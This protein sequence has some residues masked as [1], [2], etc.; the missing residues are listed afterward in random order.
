VRRPADSAP[1]WQCP[2]CG[3]AIEKFLASQRPAPAAAAV[4][5]APASAPAVPQGIP[6]LSRL[7]SAAPD[8]GSAWLFAWCWK[9]PLGWHPQLTMNLGQIM[10]M[11]FFAVHA[12]AMLGGL[13]SS[14]ASRA[15][16]L[17]A[18]LGL[19]VIYLP[20]A[21]GFA[22]AN[23]ALWPFAAFVWLLLSR[24]GTALTGRGASAFEKKRMQF[25]WGNGAACFI[26][27]AFVAVLLPVPEFGFAKMR[28]PWSGWQI[29]P[30]QVLCW[31]FL[32]FSAL[33][34]MK[35]LENPR[36]IENMRAQQP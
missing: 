6:F 23:N 2:G 3:V 9:N 10:L 31:G 17:T 16:K 27:F 25:Y 22:W 12:S 24:T 1:A 5:V 20:I 28:V 29:R 33:A 34:A 4:P 35:L 26:V 30:Q 19:L 11:E 14:E 21:G 18:S 32:Y 7:A 8:I 13:A 36:W 15:S